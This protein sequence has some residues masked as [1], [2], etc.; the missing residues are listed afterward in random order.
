MCQNSNK[1]E[2]TVHVFPSDTIPMPYSPDYPNFRMLILDGIV[3]DSLYFKV[4]FDTYAEGNSFSISDSLKNFFVSDSA[5]VQI[6]RFKKQLRINYL[7]SDRNRRNFF[8]LDALGKI[9]ILVGWQFFENKIIAFDFQNQRI[10]VYKELPDITEYSKIKIELSQS[11]NLIIPIQVVAQGKTLEDSVIIDTGY[12]GYVK[13]SSE[14][15]EKQG[16]LTKHLYF[17]KSTTC[18]F[19]PADTIK[20]GDLYVTNQNENMNIFLYSNPLG[21]LGTKTMENFSVILDLIN[22]DLYLKKK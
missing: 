18:S 13:L 2:E 22:F 10:F 14:Y 8:D 3:N 20:I 21:L 6:G 16:I 12:N 15:I 1:K 7:R 11:S 4:F 19:L 17:E 5:F 9:S